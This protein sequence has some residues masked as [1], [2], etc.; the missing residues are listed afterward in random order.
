MFTAGSIASNLIVFVAT[1]LAS[2]WFS[3]SQPACL[4][5]PTC[6]T[7]PGCPGSSLTPATPATPYAAET[8]V[9]G[10]NWNTIVLVVI[11]ALSVLGPRR[12]VRWFIYLAP[13]VEA[14]PEIQTVRV[15]PRSVSR[16]HGVR[17]ITQMGSGAIHHGRSEPQ[18]ALAPET[19]IGGG[20]AYG[21]GK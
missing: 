7:C 20:G 4:G 11:T 2:R 17:A 5:C 6:P 8:T 1:G 3:P 15:A 14:E 13:Q 12:V 18:L 21:W 9:G 19:Y 16:R 10:W